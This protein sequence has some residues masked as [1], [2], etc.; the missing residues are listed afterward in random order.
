MPSKKETTIAVIF[1]VA[2]LLS[3]LPFVSKKSQPDPEVEAGIL[4]I[5]DD[6]L[7]LDHSEIKAESPTIITS[8]SS[9]MVA[10]HEG[11]VKDSIWDDQWYTC[12]FKAVPQ[13]GLF[14]DTSIFT[15]VVSQNVSVLIIRN[16]RRIA[17]FS[18]ARPKESSGWYWSTIIDK[19]AL[20][21]PTPERPWIIT[22]D[23]PMVIG[24][25]NGT[26]TIK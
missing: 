14:V 22:S 18:F 21:P 17:E 26:I 2:I 8:L 1:V 15:D 6:T 13:F 3:A 9:G 25:N 12:D 24:V 11:K 23:T 10:Y 5:P 20:T 16:R 7:V 19:N 4:R